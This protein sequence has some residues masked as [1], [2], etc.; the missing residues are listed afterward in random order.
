M[1]TA[2]ATAAAAQADLLNAEVFFQHFFGRLTAAVAAAGGAGDDADSRS[3]PF[4]SGGGGADGDGADARILE[5]VT[6]KRAEPR[7]S[8]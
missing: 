8:F 5:E 7:V 2:A 6:G 1:D 4:G 3:S